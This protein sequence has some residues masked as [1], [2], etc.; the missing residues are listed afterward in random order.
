MPDP[1]SR[2]VPTVIILYGGTGDLAKRMVLPAIYE[3]VIRGLL[4]S[5]SGWSA[6]AA[7]T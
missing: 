2:D 4:P 5:S 1:N 7:A 3:P 6:T